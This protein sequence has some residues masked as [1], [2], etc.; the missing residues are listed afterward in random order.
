VSILW[1]KRY[2]INFCGIPAL[3]GDS[4]PVHP[5]VFSAVCQQAASTR[6]QA[7]CKIRVDGLQPT[8]PLQRCRGGGSNRRLKKGIS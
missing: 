8:E 2:L 7:A 1:R 6:W 5:G 4:G 3:L